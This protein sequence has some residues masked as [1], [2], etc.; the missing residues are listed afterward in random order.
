ME[1]QK[2]INLFDKSP[3]QPWFEINWVEINYDSR[4]THNTNSHIKF[5]TSVL[6]SGLCDYNDVYIL[7]KGIIS[8]A[9][10]AAS[11]SNNIEEVIC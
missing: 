2:I 4:V 9:A 8:V 11:N 7:F 3:N 6:K 10:V 1:Y 5:K